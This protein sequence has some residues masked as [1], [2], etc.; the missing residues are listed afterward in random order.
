MKVFDLHCDTL[1]EL[2]YA[3]KAGTPKSFAPVSYTH[4]VDFALRQQ[5]RHTLF[6]ESNKGIPVSYTHLLC[7]WPARSAKQFDQKKKPAP[8][9]QRENQ[10]KEKTGSASGP[11]SYTHLDVYKRQTLC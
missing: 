2:R 6:K 5:G 7:L 8:H 11:V 3:E 10:L 9:H 4:L 1:S